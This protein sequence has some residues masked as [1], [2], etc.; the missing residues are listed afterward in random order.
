MVV[1]LIRLVEP[2]LFVMGR[3]EEW[4]D[5]LG[6]GIEAARQAG[7]ASAEALFAHQK[8]TLAYCENRLEEARDLLQRAEHLRSRLG[9]RVGAELS[10]GHLGLVTFGHAGEQPGRWRARARTFLV[11]VLTLLGAVAIVVA[12]R[13]IAVTHDEGLP[14][15][16]PPTV[17][18]PSDEVRSPYT[19]PPI[20]SPESP[21]TQS[22][23]SES[24]D[25]SE[26]ESQ[27]ESEDESE[28]AVRAVEIAPT[29]LPF[30]DTVTGN[31]STPQEVVLTSTGTAPLT[32]SQV[33][34]DGPDG[35]EFDIGPN[36]CSDNPLP[37]GETCRL[38]I[39]FHPQADRSPRERVAR[40][41][42]THDAEGGELS[43]AL[44]GK[45]NPR[46]DVGGS[47]DD[48]GVPEPEGGDGNEIENFDG[49]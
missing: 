14:P 17:T 46:D 36:D 23:R 6:Q 38:Q 13:G 2:V 49:D 43:V 44:T 33:T 22:S 21:V 42:V 24:E 40:L 4:R 10:R 45:E 29:S 5:V 26:D 20:R 15:T 35:A 7:D 30:P 32:L 25:E 18:L 3:W 1:R 37:P 34:I 16:D 39:V 11:S 31:S 12:V 48:V 9:D 28:E 47:G 8:G 19:T 41:V 27:D